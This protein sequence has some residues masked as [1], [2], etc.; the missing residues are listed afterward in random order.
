MVDD[1]IK[2]AVFDLD[3]VITRTAIIHAEAWMEMFDLYNDRRKKNG[4]KPYESFSIDKDYP[5]YIDGMPRYNGVRNFLE[6]RNINLPW[7][8]PRDP[9]QKDTICGLGN[10]KNEIFLDKLDRQRASIIRPNVK[11]AKQWK[12]AG[13]KTAIVSSSKNCQRILKSVDLET[14]FDVRVDGVISAERKLKGKPEPDTFLEA[15]EELG[16]RPEEALIVE[17][18]LAGVEAGSK[19][20]FKYVIGIGYGDDVQKM[21]ELGADEVVKTLEDL[22]LRIESNLKSHNELPD[23]LNQINQIVKDWSGKKIF[24][25]LDYDGTLSPIVEEFDKAFLSDDMRKV[26]N[27]VSKLCQTAIVSGRGMDDVKKR[28]KIEDLYYAGSH[29][30][31]ISGPN[32]FYY[33]IEKARKLIPALDNIEKELRQTFIHV[34]GVK[35]ERKKFALAVHYR[36]APVEEESNIKQRVNKLVENYPGIVQGKGKKVIE[37]KPNV[38]WHKGKALNHLLGVLNDKNEPSYVI[39]IGDDITDEDAFLHIRQGSGILVGSHGERTFAKY[40]LS[41]VEAVKKF[42]LK[43]TKELKS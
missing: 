12:Q 7:G 39:Y 29:G 28:V 41:D 33:E 32:N 35:F 24:L 37:I 26:I 40:H 4:Q 30:F 10:H 27:E 11:V 31:E 42:L 43:I 8:D 34:E 20:Q 3:G 38:Y 9:A 15:V 22:D 17:D 16:F 14:M 5:L 18:A 23:A 19:G 21:K 25:F 6:S 2:A 1:S 36:Q 13:L